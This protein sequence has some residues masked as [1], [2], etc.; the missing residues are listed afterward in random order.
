MWV[1]LMTAI[2]LPLVVSILLFR[3]PLR[4]NNFDDSDLPH[5]GL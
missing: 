3:V 4:G 1:A 5:M 2:A